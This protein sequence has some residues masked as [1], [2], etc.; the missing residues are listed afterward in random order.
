MSKECARSEFKQLQMKGGDI[1]TYNSQFKQLV[2]NREYGINN[3]QTME[4]YVEGLPIGV[5]SCLMGQFLSFFFP[6]PLLTLAQTV[7]DLLCSL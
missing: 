5:T 3:K 4:Q 2:Q 1:N 6:F 7:R